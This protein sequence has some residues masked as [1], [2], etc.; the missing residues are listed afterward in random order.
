MRLADL[1]T[2]RSIPDK[3]TPVPPRAA[4]WLEGRFRRV[5][6]VVAHSGDRL[7]SEPIAGTQPCRREPLF[8]PLCDHSLRSAATAYDAPLRHSFDAYFGRIIGSHALSFAR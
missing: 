6:P 3:L 8:L 5:S 4:D 2:T 1:P 7:L